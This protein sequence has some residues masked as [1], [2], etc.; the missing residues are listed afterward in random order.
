MQEK[1]PFYTSGTEYDLSDQDI[2][3][4]EVDSSK[5]KKKNPVSQ[6]W[7]RLFNKAED[8]PKDEQKGFLESFSAFFS[9]ATG[10]EKDEITEITEAKSEPD[11]RLPILN[12]VKVAPEEPDNNTVATKVL[13]DPNMLNIPL[14]QNSIE[15]VNNL[16]VTENSSKEIEIEL[17]NDGVLEAESINDIDQEANIAIEEARQAINREHS[18][19]IPGLVGEDNN[20]RVEIPTKTDDLES[21][22]HAINAS[23]T[24]NRILQTQNDSSGATKLGDIATERLNQ[25]RYEDL[26]NR[27]EASDKRDRSIETEQYAIKRGIDR[28][29]AISKKQAL[30][31]RKKRKINHQEPLDTLE[32]ANPTHVNTKPD[33]IVK[34]LVDRSNNLYKESEIVGSEVSESK[35]T[36]QARTKPEINQSQTILRSQKIGETLIANIDK[37]NIASE[38]TNNSFAFER[39]IERKH[40]V[41]EEPFY[42]DGYSDQLDDSSKIL[43]KND[44]L[45]T[46]QKVNT[47]RESGKGKNIQNLSM[48]QRKALNNQKELKRAAQQGV[49]AGIIMLVSFGIIAFIW[50]LLN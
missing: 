35:N 47:E 49:T 13:N 2:D 41:K 15:N 29:R 50:S 14:T 18:T 33:T 5:K 20:D 12:S 32:L 21:D 46:N 37:S 36:Y 44:I 26:K 10:V 31:L 22:V 43:V 4:D 27:S 40:E 38:K 8:Q 1:S 39:Y 45:Q 6:L 42:D 24:E 30:E 16:L 48:Q 3:G 7:K 28:L 17:T 11:L 34:D 19:K 23:H 25:Q 9:K